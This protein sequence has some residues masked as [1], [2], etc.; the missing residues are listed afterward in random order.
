MLSSD[1]T[2]DIIIMRRWIGQTWILML[3]MLDPR[4]K[5]VLMMR[6]P[7]V[8]QIKGKHFTRLWREAKRWLKMVDSMTKRI[9]VMAQGKT[10]EDARGE[11][12]GKGEFA[13]TSPKFRNGCSQGEV[14]FDGLLQQ[15][16]TSEGKAI[17]W[18]T[19]YN[20]HPPVTE[21]KTDI[22]DEVG[23]ILKVLH[24]FAW[25][26]HFHLLSTLCLEFTH[27]RHQAM[28]SSSSF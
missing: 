27:S 1:E 5:W 12:E 10:W 26:S 4:Q 18:Y 25:L 16:G 19:C 17:Q 20:S 21:K 6:F 14:V 7:T 9:S 3:R 11:H 23:S 2:S 24:G 8:E 13:Q 28:L 22:A 15:R